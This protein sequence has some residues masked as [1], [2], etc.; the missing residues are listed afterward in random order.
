MDWFGGRAGKL[1]AWIT[2]PVNIEESVEHE[3]E[4]GKLKAE[5]LGLRNPS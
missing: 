2:Q 5:T 1:S 3:V 4:A